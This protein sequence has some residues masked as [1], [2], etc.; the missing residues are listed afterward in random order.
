[1][2]CLSVITLIVH[3]SVVI[4]Q[5]SGMFLLISAIEGSECSIPFCKIVPDDRHVHVGYRLA[6]AC[7]CTCIICI[8][9]IMSRT[10]QFERI[11]QIILSVNTV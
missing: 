2:A 9:K 7:A 4:G 10:Y 8:V 1:M 6:F 11:F 3:I 5:V